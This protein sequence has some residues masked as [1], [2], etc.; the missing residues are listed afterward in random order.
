MSHYSQSCVL[1]GVNVEEI[2]GGTLEY[3]EPE[4]SDSGH[5]E[6]RSMNDV[7][8]SSLYSKTYLSPATDKSAKKTRNAGAWEKENEKPQ[9]EELTLNPH[10][11]KQDTE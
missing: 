5:T 3:S 9:A 1:S 10:A 4:D 8:I 7:D 6:I 11:A 2:K